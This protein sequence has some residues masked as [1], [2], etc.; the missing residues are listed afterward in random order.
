[1]T[2]TRSTENFPVG[3]WLIARAHRPAVHAFYAFAREVDDIADDPAREAPD[4][5]VALDAYDA[6]L[7]G[8]AGPETA[9]ALREIFA[10][11]GL[12][13]EHAR[14]LLQ[15]FKADAGGRNC[16]NWSDLL[17][18][19]RYSA[20]PVGRFLLDLHGEAK[21]IWLASDALCASLQILNHLQDAQTDWL[22]LRRRYIPGEW[23]ERSGLTERDLLA[24]R[25]SPE[26][27]AIYDRALDRVDQLN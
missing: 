15:A 12:P 8:G 25:L 16:R 7:L 21:E 14:H 1:M 11:R 9:V 19:C 22:D 17:A 24:E 13:I 26:L 27:R 20:A 10:A 18:Y 5:L 4:K 3:S 2:R 6:A 23:L